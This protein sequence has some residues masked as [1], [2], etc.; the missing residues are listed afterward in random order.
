MRNDIML[1]CK[2]TVAGTDSQIRDDI[3]C[4]LHTASK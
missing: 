3:V 2:V 4:C 1:V